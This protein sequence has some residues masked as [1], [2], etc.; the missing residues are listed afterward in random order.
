MDAIKTSPKATKLARSALHYCVKFHMYEPRATI[1]SY[2]ISK[3]ISRSCL[4]ESMQRSTSLGGKGHGIITTVDPTSNRKDLDL[5]EENGVTRPACFPGFL[6]ELKK[7]Q[8]GSQ[9]YK[10]SAFP[11]EHTKNICSFP[12]LTLSHLSVLR[13]V[14]PVMLN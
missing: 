8:T 12:T 13:S 4:R 1:Y 9:S 11:L 5:Q 2:Y 7:I 6:E 14:L 3:V 10:T